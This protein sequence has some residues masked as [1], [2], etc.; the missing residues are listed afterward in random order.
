MSGLKWDRP[1]AERP[2]PDPAKVKRKRHWPTHHTTM[3]TC[4]C[5]VDGRLTLDELLEAEAAH[6]C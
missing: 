4:G 5:T 2:E 6:T 1:R 3:L